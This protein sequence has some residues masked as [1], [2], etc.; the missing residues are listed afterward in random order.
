MSNNYIFIPEIACCCYIFLLLAF[1]AAKKTPAVKAFI[2]A[3]VCCLIWTAGSVLMRSQIEPSINLWFSISILG[4]FMLA[5]SLYLFILIFVGKKITIMAKIWFILIILMV[6][7]NYVTGAFLKSPKVVTTSTNNIIFI[8]TFNWHVCIF[9]AVCGG[10]IISTL[11]IITTAIIENKLIKEQLT[12]IV[13][14]IAIIFVSQLL[15][16]LPQM[17]G[18][19]IDVLSSLLMVICFIYALYRRRLIR[20]TLLVSRGACYMASAILSVA[21]FSNFITPIGHLVSEKFNFLLKYDTLIIAITFTIFAVCLYY[22]MKTFIDNVFIKDEFIKA[23]ALKEFSQNVSKSLRIDEILEKLINIIHN[24]LNINKVYVFIESSDKSVYR[25]ARTLSPLDDKT[26][27]LSESNP[28]VNHFKTNNECLL[29]KDFKKLSAYKSMWEKEKNEIEKMGIDCF[30]PLCDE[31]SLVG[32]VAISKNNTTEN[33]NYDDIDFLSS[34]NSISSI[35]I[36]NSTLYEKAYLEARTDELTGLLNRKYCCELL[37]TEYEKHKNSSLSLAIINIDDFKLYNQLYGNHEGDLALQ[38][39][40]KII[41]ASVGDNGHTA[42]YSSKEFAII[43]PNYDVLSAKNLVE[44]IRKQILNINK[45]ESNYVLKALTVSCGISSIPYDASNTNELIQNADMSVFQVKR[46]GKNGIMVYSGTRENDIKENNSSSHREDVYS[47]YAPTIYALTAA[48]DTKDHYTFNHSNNVSYYASELGYAFELNE[49]SVEIIREAAL[50]HDIGKIGISENILNK[51]GTLTPEEFE[52]MKGHVENSIGI[53]KHLPSLDYVIPAVIG[54]HE[55][56]DGEGYPR[57]IAGKDI[58]LLAR[59]LC[60]AD[61]FDAMISSRTYKKPY[62]VKF[63]LSQLKQNSGTQF[64]PV[65]AEKFIELVENGDI[66]P[67]AD[68]ILNIV[69]K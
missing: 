32:I 60:I 10:I 47:E 57:R 39:V 2:T 5:W 21:I 26:F 48:I 30:A 53:I 18:F 66:I 6:S 56:Y 40:G 11:Y 59:I 3:L 45:T 23:N 27:Y 17:K 67:K 42:R 7:I 19:P 63:A 25:I 35:A 51:P 38:N 54:H 31:E 50:L 12:P 14:G 22:I 46:N 8:Y 16:L 33:F 41:S 13:F 36:K 9:F 64:D 43:L 4:L 49:D 24:T 68:E 61:S 62:T 20:L 34:V 37:D 69:N 55:R 29:F 15:L 65:L 52:I 1:I 58:P 28:L 44:T